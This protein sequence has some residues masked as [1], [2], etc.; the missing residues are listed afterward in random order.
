MYVDYEEVTVTV[1]Y[2][3]GFLAYREVPHYITMLKRLYETEKHLMPQVVRFEITNVLIHN[4]GVVALLSVNMDD[5]L[6]N[7]TGHWHYEF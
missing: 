7:A 6:I 5:T 2:A 3:S 1:D 4:S